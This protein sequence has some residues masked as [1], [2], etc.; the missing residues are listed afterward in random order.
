MLLVKKIIFTASI[1]VFIN[2]VYAETIHQTTEMTVCP[3]AIE[4]G[5]LDTSSNLKVAQVQGEWMVHGISQFNTS[6]T[7]QFG[8]IHSLCMNCQTEEE[9]LKWAPMVLLFYYERKV[10]KPI[11]FNGMTICKYSNNSSVDIAVSPVQDNEMIKSILNLL[12]K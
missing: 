9:A 5:K 10:S 4:I 7:W 2:P 8:A 1:L 12:N 3:S 11:T 6:K